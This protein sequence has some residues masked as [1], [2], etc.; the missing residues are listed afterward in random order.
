MV[1]AGARTYDGWFVRSWTTTV[2]GDAAGGGVALH[3]LQWSHAW[4]GAG[5]AGACSDAVSAFP[6]LWQMIENGSSTAVRVAGP[7]HKAACMAIAVIATMLRARL[8]RVR[9]LSSDRGDGLPEYR[10][11]VLR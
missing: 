11:R 4:L 7:P 10:Y 9:M 1:G 3:K 8:K 5:L 6:P 2:D